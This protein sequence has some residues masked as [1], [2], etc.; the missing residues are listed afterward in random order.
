[1]VA[2]YGIADELGFQVGLSCGG[3]IDVLIEPFVAD[4]AW[5]A[6]RVAVESQRPVAAGIGLAPAPLLGRKLAVL[7]PEVV[8]CIDPELDRPVAAAARE[9]LLSGGTR[10]LAVPWRGA[11]ATIF[12][13]TFPPPP[14]LVIVGATHTAIAL[15]RIA[16]GLGFRVSVIDARGFYATRERFPDADEV[17]M[18]WPTEV[19][20]EAALDDYAYLVVLSHDPKFDVPALARALR[21]QSRYIGVM[22]SRATHERRRRALLAEGFSERELARIRAPIGLDIGARTP[23]E[24]AVA[25]VAEML[26]VRSGRDGRALTERKAAIHAD[27]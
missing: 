13:E 3:S 26:A 21:S 5:Q 18:Q 6:L 20:D 24:I 23:D 19:L 14:R 12:V 4:D 25:I 10:V 17:I 1:V 8:G 7:G 9:L 22:G 2:S 27:D 16:K 11:Q 15:S